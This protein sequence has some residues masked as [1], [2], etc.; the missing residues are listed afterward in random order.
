MVGLYPEPDPALPPFIPNLGLYQVAAAIEAGGFDDLDLAIWDSPE[1]DPARIAAEIEAFDPDIVGFSAYVWSLPALMRIHAAIKPANPARLTVFGGPSARENMLGHPPFS[2]MPQPDVLVIGEGE[3]AMR[4]IVGLARRD[5]A[6]LGKVRGL[7]LRHADGWQQTAPRH[8]ALMDSLASPYARGLIPRRGL[9]IM[10]TYR[11]CPFSCA[12]CEWGVM[13][14]PRNVRGVE[15]I[16]RE[17][18]AIEATGR[19]SLLLVDAGLNLNKQAFAN[20]SQA[21][22][23]SGFLRTRHLICEV[24]PMQIRDEHLAFLGDT[25]GAHVGVGLQSFDQAVLNEVERRYDE[26]RFNQILRDLDSVASLA[27][28]IILGLPGDSPER[29][30]ANFERARQLPYALRV[31]HCLVLP[32]ALMARSPRSHAL[33]YDP[34]TLKMRSC[35]GWSRETLAETADFVSA[36]ARRAGGATGAFFW[37]FPPP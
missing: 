28:E 34:V 26:A 12:F 23:S 9:G 4:E 14:A 31:Y 20:L 21:A 27:I 36:E 33:D 30:R 2:R 32:S 6:T 37:V 1:A 17:F 8:P 29:F 10:E 16:T 24:Y 18:E 19:S 7:A 3:T 11:G 13:E 15:G 25:G 22:R 35:L 5:A